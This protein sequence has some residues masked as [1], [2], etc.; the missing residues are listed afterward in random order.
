MKIMLDNEHEIIR[1]KRK[2]IRQF[3]KHEASKFSVT[4]KNFESATIIWF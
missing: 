3:Y 2:A 1:I 4:M